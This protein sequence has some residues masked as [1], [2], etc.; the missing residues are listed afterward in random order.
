[1]TRH[2]KTRFLRCLALILVLS[3]CVRIVNMHPYPPSQNDVEGI[4]VVSL[5]KH[6]L[7]I[8]KVLVPEHLAQVYQMVRLYLLLLEKADLLHKRHQYLQVFV[9]SLLRILLE[10]LDD[11]L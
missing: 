6:K 2:C 7:A 3:L 10:D 4:S 11:H 1:M 9:V 5:L 8:F